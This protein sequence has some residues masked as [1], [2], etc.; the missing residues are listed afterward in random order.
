MRTK[1]LLTIA[2]LCA[3]GVASSQAQVFSVNA[4]GYVNKT[5]PANSFAMIANPLQAATNTI[6]A[7]FAGVPEGFSV[8]VY[9]PGTGYSIGAFDALEGG[10]TPPAVGNY[11]LL[12]GGGVF[13]KN[14]TAQPVSI[15]FV[16][17]V[18]QG[19]PL[20]TPLV[21]GLQIVSSKVPQAGTP[22]VLGLTAAPG[23]AIYLYDVATQKY[24]ISGYDDLEE[25]GFSPIPR[26]LE[27][28]EAF[29]LKKGAAGTWSR[30]FTV[31]Q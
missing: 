12:P 31:N 29:F 2:A 5:I 21:A 11:E 17:E 23:D 22:A 3:A 8:Y 1:T 9:Q 24:T 27:V 15:T 10:F 6:N 25:G 18:L 16:G 28:G 30:N 19:T 14:P 13:V 26:A 7:L 4:V 20:T